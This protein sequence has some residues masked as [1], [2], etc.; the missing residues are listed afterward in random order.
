MR[1]PTKKDFFL[2]EYSDFHDGT[3]IWAQERGGWNWYLIRPNGGDWKFWPCNT[4]SPIINDPR[5]IYK[6]GSFVKLTCEADLFA[7]LL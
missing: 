2:L 3:L 6:D 4:S 5:K 1:V 7:A